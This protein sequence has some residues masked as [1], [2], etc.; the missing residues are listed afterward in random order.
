MHRGKKFS[1]DGAVPTDLY[2]FGKHW[3]VVHFD[4]FI[5]FTRM[6]R[7]LHICIS[8][9]STGHSPILNTYFFRDYM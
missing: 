7:C 5:F 4:L 6:E 2:W 8:S 1:E 3:G 9:Y